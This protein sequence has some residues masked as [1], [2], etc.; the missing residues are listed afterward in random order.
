LATGSEN[1]ILRCVG[2]T[3]RIPSEF[4]L[5]PFSLDEARDAGLTRHSLRRQTWKRIGAR[6]YR[7]TDLPEDLLLTL[8]AWRSVLPPET[9]FA[10]ASAAW[11]HG[12]DIEPADPV[13]V[14]VPPS[15]AVRTRVGLIVRHARIPTAEV[16]SVR[17]FRATDLPLALA[18]LCLQRPAVEALVAIDMAIYRGLIDQTV[19]A[20]YA[21]ESKLRAGV[22]RMKSLAKLA[23][24]AESPME[25]RLRWL[26][27]QAGLPGPQVQAE[28]SDASA[29]LLGRVDLY[30]AE[31]RL[32][33]EYDG[34]YHRERMVEDNRRQNLLISSGYRVLRFTAADIHN[35]ADVVIAQ[36]R[37]ALYKPR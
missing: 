7:W 8:S 26:L 1:G 18:R 33:V 19:L 32:A 13:E 17:G 30:Y 35:R 24:P 28:L 9:V 23:A 4:R 20:Q 29:R 22:Q 34:G 3:P 2:K 36:V 21:E 5:R 37:A 25:T 6:L 31:A 12:L 11:L 27:I 14:V 15:C 16:V 10:G